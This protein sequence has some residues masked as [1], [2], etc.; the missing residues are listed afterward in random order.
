MSF[1]PGGSTTESDPQRIQM[2]LFDASAAA[3]PISVMSRDLLATHHGCFGGVEGEALVI[4]FA[5]APTGAAF[6]PPAF[7]V[8]SFVFGG[9]PHLFTTR[10]KQNIVSDGHAAARLVVEI[11]RA[12]TRAESR[13]SVRVQIE[14]GVEL[15]ARIDAEGTIATAT[16]V[17]LSLCGVLLELGHGGPQLAPDQ[18]IGVELALGEVVARL[19]G[20]VRRVESP[21]YGIY[22]PDA[23][24]EGRLVPPAGLREIV[25][26]ISGTP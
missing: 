18:R 13:M 3:L 22:F 14:P 4:G 17:D 5:E 1:A 12:I 10:V 26:R 6:R 23:V 25:R 20:I 7:C 11:P 16:A 9:R 8:A 15:R 2:I 24:V 21:R 19:R